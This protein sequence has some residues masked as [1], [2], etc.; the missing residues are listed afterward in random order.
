MNFIFIHL[1][2]S[3]YFDLRFLPLVNVRLLDFKVDSLN[4]SSTTHD[5][6]TT[7]VWL[8]VVQ[9]TASTLQE[10]IQSANIVMSQWKY[11]N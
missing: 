1:W 5:L 6:N 2:C 11:K 10:A 7:K 4:A 3:T 8:K 9:D